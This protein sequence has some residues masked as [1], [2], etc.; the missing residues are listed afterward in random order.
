MSQRK[1]DRMTLRL[2]C[3]SMAAIIAA[4]HASANVELTNQV[5]Q[6]AATS[7]ELAPR[8]TLNTHEWLSKALGESLEGLNPDEAHA[9]A[10]ERIPGFA[11]VRA[12]PDGSMSVQFSRGAGFERAMR[13]NSSKKR[14]EVNLEEAHGKLLEAAGSNAKLSAVSFNARQLLD[15]KRMALAVN[16]AVMW[17]DI[18]H[19]TNR[20][21]LGINKDLSADQFALV[22]RALNAAGIPYEA[23]SSE[24]SEMMQPVQSTGGNI[25]ST[26]PPLRGG[27]Q[28][29]WFDTSAGGSFVCSVSAPAT[30]NGVAGF[31]TASHCGNDTYRLTST[32]FGSPNS[33]STNVGSESVDPTGFSCSLGSGFGACRNSDAAFVTSGS[34]TF[35]TM[36][37]ISPTTLQTLRVRTFNGSTDFQGVG[38]TV[39]KSGRTTG[40]T[41]GTVTRDCVDTRVGGSPNYVVLCATFTN[42]R[43]DGG[44]SGGT[45]YGVSGTNTA[46]YYG[47][48]SFKDGSGNGGYSPFGQI[49][50]DLGTLTIF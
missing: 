25:Q 28:I 50:R 35:G 14:G 36:W 16:E 9:R 11:G 48:T 13:A 7:L 6:E 32:T 42:A 33:N 49:K 44:D 23:M 10:A 34:T 22:E 21:H 46:T 24:P 2:L 27:S 26:P 12:M 30:R 5:E 15:W 19:E 20:L 41:S 40:T 38:S 47:V 1:N 37:V 8:K 17:V 29:S 31:I 3:A 39:N 43:V 45:W 4:G 18:D